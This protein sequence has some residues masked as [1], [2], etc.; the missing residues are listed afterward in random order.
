MS[1]TIGWKKINKKSRDLYFDDLEVNDAFRN[2]S[3]RSKGAVYIKVYNQLTDQYFAQEVETGRL[4]TPTKAPV[5]KVSVNIE[6]DSQKP[7]IYH[8]DYF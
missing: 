6:I 4:W 7:E 3:S 1:V 5:E 2:K 8:E